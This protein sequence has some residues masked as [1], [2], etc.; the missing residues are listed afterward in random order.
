MRS[1]SARR[2]VYALIL[3]SAAGAIG[4][5]AALPAESGSRDKIINVGG[6]VI[7]MPA[8]A[9]MQHWHVCFQFLN[10][11]AWDAE[12]GLSVRNAMMRKKPVLAIHPCNFLA[13]IL[14]END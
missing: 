10:G 2:F 12:S 1:N 8:G 13:E 14:D 6:R 11:D 4:V 5:C 7:V 9:S 3:G